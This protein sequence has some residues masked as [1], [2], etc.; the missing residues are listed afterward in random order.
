MILRKL[1]NIWR[2]N[3]GRSLKDRSCFLIW[4]IKS[5]LMI[6]IREEEEEA[7]VEEVEVEVEE[8]VKV[9]R[10]RIVNIVF[11]YYWMLIYVFVIEY[12]FLIFFYKK[13]FFFVDFLKIFFVKNFSYNIINDS[14]VDVFDGCL[15]VRVVMERD[16][17]GRLRGWVINRLK[18]VLFIFVLNI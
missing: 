8:E 5:R 16:N 13:G 2:L 1:R 14:L 9:V 3:R 15:F 11:Y 17:F 6:G 18:I 4:L 12:C 10:I 7:G